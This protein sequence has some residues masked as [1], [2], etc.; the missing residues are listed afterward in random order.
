MIM[1][2]YYLV[3]VRGTP[4]ETFALLL[5][6]PPFSR[7][8]LLSG[9]GWAA[10]RFGA[11]ASWRG[12]AVLAVSLLVRQGF[13]RRDP[14]AAVAAVMALTSV[15]GAIVQTPGGDHDVKRA[16]RSR[17]CGVGG[18]SLGGRNFLQPRF[19]TCRIAGCCPVRRQLPADHRPA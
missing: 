7:R 1:A 11:R 17:W 18:E 6:P 5:V 12:L 15:G 10:Q 2:T 9:A 19:G 14:I 4:I 16:N 8:S 3:I 13:Q